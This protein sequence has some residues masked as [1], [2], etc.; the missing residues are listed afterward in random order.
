[1]VE[2]PKYHE[3]GFYLMRYRLRHYLA[4]YFGTLVLIFLGSSVVALVFLNPDVESE[5]WLLINFA[6]GI[7]VAMALYVSMGSSGGHLNSAITISAAVYG[8]LPW[9]RVPGYI[10]SQILGAFTGSALTYGVYR[11]RFD[12]FD[13]GVRSVSGP[14]AT[15]GIFCT[16]PNPYNTHWDSFFT[17][18]LL[19]AILVFVVQGIF[20]PEMTPAKG[21]EPFIVGLLV[22]AIGMTTGRLTGSAMNPA[23]DFGPRLFTAVSGWGSAPFTASGHYFWIPIVAPVIGAILGQGAYGLFIIPNR[24]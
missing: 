19:T 15:G 12:P 8:K 7:A 2:E 24:D 16:Y 17:E 18:M 21:F 10:F 23:R 6:W 1:M 13:N 22:T 14:T 9:H 3:S 20:D 11:S 4:E 5:S